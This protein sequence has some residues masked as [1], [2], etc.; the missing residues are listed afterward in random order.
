MEG[1]QGKVPRKTFPPK[2]YLVNEKWRRLNIR[3]IWYRVTEKLLLGCKLGNLDIDRKV[4]SFYSVMGQFLWRTQKWFLPHT[5]SH[6]IVKLYCE[7]GYV[8]ACYHSWLHMF[9]SALRQGIWAIELHVL[10]TYLQYLLCF[11]QKWC[12]SICW[13]FLRNIC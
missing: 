2:K 13:L 8:S 3:D 12:N 11:V 1:V 7:A 9:L 5:I 4:W 6:A 10:H